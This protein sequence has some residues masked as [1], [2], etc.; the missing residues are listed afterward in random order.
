MFRTA[1]QRS[2]QR[3]NQYATQA[4]AHV[5]WFSS[6]LDWLYDKLIYHHCLRFQIEF[7]FRNSRRR[8]SLED[9]MNVNPSL[10][11]RALDV[12]QWRRYW[13]NG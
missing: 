10:H 7:D 13:G 8:W 9:F 2:H 5:I 1:V 6:D 3:Q 4:R 12:N 11:D